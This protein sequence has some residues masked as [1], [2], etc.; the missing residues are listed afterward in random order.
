MTY[1]P[2]SAAVTQI[3]TAV[4][5]AVILQDAIRQL[6]DPAKAQDVVKAS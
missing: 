4:T 2:I 1:N 6:T 3:V 5:A